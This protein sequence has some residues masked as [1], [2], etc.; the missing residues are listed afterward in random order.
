MD[1][2]LLH[3]LCEYLKRLGVHTTAGNHPVAGGLAMETM[4]CVWI[5]AGGSE[6]VTA[7]GSVVSISNK[8]YNTT[9]FQETTCWLSCMLSKCVVRCRLS[10]LTS[11]RVYMFCLDNTEARLFVQATPE[12]LWLYAHPCIPEELAGCRWICTYSD[13]C[14]H[15]CH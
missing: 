10:E 4:S 2:G 1:R 7:C 12:N 13:A 14:A 3:F 8:T 15:A 6:H 9:R 11:T 5:D